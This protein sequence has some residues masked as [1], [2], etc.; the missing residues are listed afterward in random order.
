VAEHHQVIRVTHQ[1]PTPALDPLPVEPVQIDVAQ[2]GRD[3]AA[4]RGAGHIAADRTVLHHPRAQHRAQ[5][6]EQVAIRD[7]F[8]DRQHQPRVRNRL[9]TV[10]DIRLQSPPPPLQDSSIK[11]W[12]ASCC[13][14]LGRNPNEHARKSASNTGSITSLTAA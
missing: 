8:L 4:L 1:H 10:G 13:D 7:P 11:T 6:L 2:D 3:N 14:R 5:Q 9:K 12:S